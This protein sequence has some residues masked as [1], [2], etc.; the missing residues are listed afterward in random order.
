MNF[1]DSRNS[2]ILWNETYDIL[3]PQKVCYQISELVVVDQ[4]QH[5]PTND[6][7]NFSAG[8]AYRY[9]NKLNEV[10]QILEIFRLIDKGFIS[11][12]VKEISLMKL[13]TIKELKNFREWVFMV[14]FPSRSY[15]DIIEVYYPDERS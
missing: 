6:Y 15:E 12:G 14:V 1:I 8:C 11:N 10:Q 4:N 13:A 9:W 3:N 2:L 7:Y 5:S